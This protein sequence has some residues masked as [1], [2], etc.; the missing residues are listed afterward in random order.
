MLRPHIFKQRGTWWACEGGRYGKPM[1]GFE[2]FHLLVLM[3][4]EH[5]DDSA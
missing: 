1:H 4:K 5:A 3:L 2:D